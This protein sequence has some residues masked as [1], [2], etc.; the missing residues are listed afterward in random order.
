MF[1][2][3]LHILRKETSARECDIVAFRQ[4]VHV[5]TKGVGKNLPVVV[6]YT[7]GTTSAIFF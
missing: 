6:P 2:S 1:A 4:R 7:I 5:R 3:L